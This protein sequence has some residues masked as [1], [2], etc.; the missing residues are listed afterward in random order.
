VLMSVAALVGDAAGY[1]EGRRSGA[2]LRT[3]RIGAWVGQRRWDRADALF[4]RHGGRAVALG[5]FVAFARTL[6]PRLAGIAGVPYR[7]VLPWNVLGVLGWVGGSVVAGYLA[8]DSYSRVADVLGRATAAVLLLVLV[9]IVLVVLGRFLGRH[10]DPVAAFGQRVVHTWPL[11]RLEGWY[12]RAFRHL[13]ARI[14]AGGAVT[15][16]LTLG[17]LALLAVGVGLTWSI[18]HLVRQSGLPLVDPPLTHWVVAHRTAAAI[19]WAH[20]TLMVLRGSFIVSA[21]ATLSLVLN[22]RPRRWGSDLLALLGTTGTFIPL[23]I[24]AVASDWAHSSV[25]HAVLANQVTMVTAG[26][27][28]FAWLLGRRIRWAIAVV[29]WVAATGGVILVAAASLYLGRSRPSEIAASLLMGSLWVLV[30]VVAWHTRARLK[31][32]E[33][34]PRVPLREAVTCPSSPNV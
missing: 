22:P 26:L 4:Q 25:P 11:R 30:F 1:A 24:L 29:A 34:T 28:M 23:L 3:G 14:G 32:E 21:V 20:V 18:D 2:R 13:T 17:V 16:N 10:R 7:R 15:V 12:T 33:Q 19:R 9:L 27:G 31:T 8:G 5:R 6:V